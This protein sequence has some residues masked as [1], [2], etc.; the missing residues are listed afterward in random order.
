MV[1][2][3]NVFQKS[4]ASWL[5]A[6]PPILL[7]SLSLFSTNISAHDIV[8]SEQIAVEERNG[9]TIPLDMMFADE[10][11]NPVALKSLMQTPVILNLAYYTC[12]DICPQIFAGIAQALPKLKLIPKKDFSVITVSFD[13]NDTPQIARE[14]KKNYLKAIDIPFPDEAWRFLTGKREQIEGLTKSVGFAFRREGHEF[15]HPVTLIILSPDGTINRY[16]Y[17]PKS[18]Y[19]VAY[20]VNFSALELRTGL[21]DAAQGKIGAAVNRVF[22]Y[23]FPHEPKNQAAFFRLLSIIGAATLVIILA[24]F[25]FLKKTTAKK[26]SGTTHE[27]K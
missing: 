3:L 27:S 18:A 23:C 4:A 25:I 24:L 2:L 19:G 7:V 13:E 12:K 22:L 10:Q 20:P 21:T 15:I 6:V 14:T 1:H 17:V 9:Q 26:D 5:R 8:S 11:G 16:I